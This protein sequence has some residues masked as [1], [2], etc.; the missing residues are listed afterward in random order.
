MAIQHHAFISYSHAADAR[1]APAFQRGIER[2]AKPL[3]RLRALNIFRD[4]TSLTASPALWPGIVAHLSVSE[5]FLLFACPESAASRWCTRE[6]QWWLDNR[7]TERLLVVLTGGEIVWDIER[8][9]FDWARTTALA[10]ALTGCFA[11]EPLFVDL[12]WARQA[13]SLGP[14]Q[15]A[16]R[17]ALVAIAAPLRGMRRDE[18]DGA[19]LRQLRRNRLYVRSGVAS[20]TL[21][22]AIAAWQAFVAREQRTIA[23][24]ERDDAQTQRVRAEEGEQAATVERDHALQAQAEADEQRGIATERQHEAEVQT[25][26]A[27]KQR[28]RAEDALAA[29]E[30]ELLRAQGAELRAMV[31]RV[32][33]LIA[34]AGAR[35]ANVGELERE[36]EQLQ[37]RLADT[38]RRLQARLAEKMGFRG[39]LAWIARWEG[40]TGG[41]K[42]I[43]GDVTID[44]QT[45]LMTTDA[46]TLRQRYEFLLTPTEMDAVASLAGKRGDEARSAFEARRAVLDR[47]RLEPAEVARLVPEATE[48]WWQT[49]LKRYPTLNE[50]TTPASVHT[51]VL[52]LAFN[53][54]PGGSRWQPV[55]EAIAARDWRRVADR[56]ENFRIPSFND[57]VI[58]QAIKRRRS[59]EADLIRNELGGAPAPTRAMIAPAVEPAPPAGDLGAEPPSPASTPAAPVPAPPREVVAAAPAPVEFAVVNPTDQGLDLIAH[60]EGFT[61]TLLELGPFSIIGYSHNVTDAERKAGEIR[62]GNAVIQLTQ[63]IGEDQARVLLTADL[64]RVYRFIASRISVPLTPNQRDALASYLFNVGNRGL[65]P[66][67]VTELNAGNYGIVPELLRGRGLGSTPT[68]GLWGSRRAAE[69]ELWSRQ[70]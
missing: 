63:P 64:Q 20:I 29:T 6:V 62:V 27:V 60:Y 40:S 51:A 54:G 53:V 2:L 19:D 34:K 36:H 11:D 10:P 49:L 47:I 48:P 58:Q 35:G 66:Q 28:R 33:D 45:S 44:P 18:L 31:K 42:L 25:G 43:G 59:A 61:P 46:A 50:P 17:D 65:S 70:D 14:E 3:L 1:L 16:F 12:R 5:W 23:E 15:A 57:A 26:I 39:D 69:A 55:A 30:R 24:H 13:E 4:Q 52:S 38:T 41:V 56:I 9:D 21:A 67:M 68:A 37:A 8:G 22:A 7:T 32:E